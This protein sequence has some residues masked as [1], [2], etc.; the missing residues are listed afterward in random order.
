MPDRCTDP[1]CQE[2]WPVKVALSQINPEW[3]VRLTAFEPTP[4]GATI[5]ETST[6]Q[7]TPS[8]ADE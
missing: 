4:T 5:W 2:H 3:S 1:T 6:A 7:L 8:T